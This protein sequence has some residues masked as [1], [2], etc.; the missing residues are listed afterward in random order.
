MSIYGADTSCTDSF[1]PGTLVSGPTLVAEA[2]YRRWTT[3]RGRLLE[4]PHYGLTIA[5]YLSL[6]LTPENAARIPAELKAEAM[7]DDRLDSCSYTST[8]TGTG[9]SLT[10]Q[11]DFDFECGEGPFSLS[12]TLT[13]TSF[14]VIIGKRGAA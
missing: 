4:D 10:L 2:V 7:K 5:D 9:A 13:A 3:P 1:K 8:L 14:E 6:E 12:V 11:A